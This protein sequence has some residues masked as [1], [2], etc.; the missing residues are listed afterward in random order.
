MIAKEAVSNIVEHAGATVVEIDLCVHEGRLR[1]SIADDGCGLP[2]ATSGR[3]HG[4]GGNGQGNMQ[5]RAA[6][7]G[8]S[9]RI[10]TAAPRG[11]RVVVEVPLSREAH[12]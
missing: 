8:G 1:M 5:S 10:E 6:D 7:L 11:T 12:A 4:P 2:E 9:C 3:R